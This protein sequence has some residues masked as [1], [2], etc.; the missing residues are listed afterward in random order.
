M[1]IQINRHFYKQLVSVNVKPL[2]GNLVISLK[3]LNMRVLL[4]W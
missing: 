4:T 3:I 1:G 2:G